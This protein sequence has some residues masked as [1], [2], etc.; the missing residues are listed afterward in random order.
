MARARL[1]PRADCLEERIKISKETVARIRRT[2]WPH[3]EPASRPTSHVR[4]PLPPYSILYHFSPTLVRQHLS[5]QPMPAVRRSDVTR[6]FSAS[7]SVLTLLTGI[8]LGLF[9]RSMWKIFLRRR[10][11][12]AWVQSCCIFERPPTTRF[13]R[14][15]NC[16]TVSSYVMCGLRDRHENESFQRNEI[17]LTT[18]ELLYLLASLRELLDISA[19]DNRHDEIAM[20]GRKDR[21]LLD[22]DE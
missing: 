19:Y 12:A 7:S 14:W 11:A 15:I 8:T 3:K 17:G 1:C 4:I 9:C 6:D 16:R 20:T 22:I 21:R 18:M 10:R 5:L 13:G 2:L